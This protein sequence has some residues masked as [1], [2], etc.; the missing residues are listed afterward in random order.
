MA[1]WIALVASSCVTR[2]VPNSTCEA[3]WDA[4][5]LSQYVQLKDIGL[6]SEKVGELHDGTPIFT[7]KPAP[8]LVDLIDELNAECCSNLEDPERFPMCDDDAE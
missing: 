6:P 5:T 2:T 3:R 7:A 1:L 8:A 4:E